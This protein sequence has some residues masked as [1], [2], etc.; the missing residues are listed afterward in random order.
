MARALWGF[1]R[2]HQGGLATKLGWTDGYVRAIVQRTTKQ[3]VEA[4]DTDQ[5]AK[6]ARKAGFPEELVAALVAY[7]TSPGEDEGRRPDEGGRVDWDRP[8]GGGPSEGE[9]DEPGMGTGG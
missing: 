4:P 9:A 2:E 7:L 8:L 3:G 5:L 1:S 6:M